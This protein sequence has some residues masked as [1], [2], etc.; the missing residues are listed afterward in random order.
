MCD[1]LYLRT[2]AAT[3]A[4]KTMTTTTATSTTYDQLATISRE[5]GLL[6]SINGLLGWDQETTMPQGGAT[7]RARQLALVARLSHE[8]TASA[9]TGEL[10]T[11]CEG[12]MD[13]SADTVEAAN[14]RAWRHDHDRA[15]RLPASLVEELAATASTAQ[16]EWADARKNNDFKRFLPWLEKTID[17][18]RR[19]AEC[20]GWAEG[21]EPWDALAE[22]YEP[23]CTAADV[24]TVFGPLRDRLKVLLD[25]IMGASQRPSGR[26]DSIELPIEAQMSF[27]R[28]IAEEIGF[29]FGRGR[30]DRSIHPFCGGSHCDDVRMTTRFHDAMLSDGVSS[31]MH[32]AGH[33]MYEQGI[34]FEHIGTPCGNSVSL[35]IHESQSRMWENQVGRSE[36][37]WRWCAP[38]LSGHFGPAVDGIDARAAYESSNRV[39]PGFI[40]VE[41]DEA[42][43]NM[44]VMIRFELERS[45]M[46]GDLKPADVPAAW[47]ERYRDYLGLEVPDDRRG[48]LQDI[49]WS[50]GALGYFPTYTLGNLY[51]AQLFDAAREAIPGLEEGFAEGRFSPLLDWLRENI[52]QHG[53]RYSA[54]QLC[55]RVTGKPLS[56]DPL[57][58][59]LE[60]KFR[61]LHGI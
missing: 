6:G 60:T 54:A 32:E 46:T 44:H 11:A 47:N 29:D 37:F 7:Y 50:M 27:S 17:L 20:Y 8:R 40:R 30:L 39:E 12:E 35:G 16:H 1:S 42:T 15:V 51:C 56:A 52:H 55:E 59:Y 61:A 58:H 31:T 38:R 57:M 4:L 10:I 9:E 24:A 18:S 36:S 48:C 19:K 22:D 2:N 23:G 43:Y 53:R 5:T 26:L 25:A 14:L 21:G 33:G 13:A 34:P 49:H 45:L 41:A 28:E 3:Q